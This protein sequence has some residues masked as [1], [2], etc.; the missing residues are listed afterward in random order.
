M[1]REKKNGIYEIHVNGIPVYV[2]ES[3][4]IYKRCKTH[5]SYSLSAAL[6]RY[7]GDE[8]LWHFLGGAI[9]DGSS[10]RYVVQHVNSNYTKS[11]RLAAE[12]ARILFLEAVGFNMKCNIKHHGLSAQTKE[13]ISQARIGVSSGARDYTWTDEQKARL[14]RAMKGKRDAAK[15]IV[16]LEKVPITHH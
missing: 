2:G 3:H 11:D 13:K 6:G 14:S 8:P 9:K 5:R 16:H 15:P 7:S 1:K 10:I 12:K 4:D